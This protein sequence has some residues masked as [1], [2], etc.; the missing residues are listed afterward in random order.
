MDYDKDKRPEKDV[1][2]TK[3]K[4]LAGTEAKLE[5]LT[6]ENIQ[7]FIASLLIKLANFDKNDYKNV[8]EAEAQQE[9]YL[10]KWE[11]LLNDAYRE[12]KPKI[13]AAL[14]EGL[15]AMPEE[16]RGKLIDAFVRVQYQ[17]VKDKDKLFSESREFKVAVREKDAEKLKNLIIG[18]FSQ[19]TSADLA[20]KQ[21]IAAWLERGKNKF[22]TKLAKDAEMDTKD[23]V[24]VVDSAFA[25]VLK[26][27]ETT[28]FAPD[29]KRKEPLV[30]STLLNLIDRNVLQLSGE[31]KKT[32]GGFIHIETKE[33]DVF[34]TGLFDDSLHL[35]ECM[36]TGVCTWNDRPRQV[37][38]GPHFAVIA[39]KDKQGRVYAS[40][41]VQLVKTPIDGYG[42]AAS[43][44]GYYILSLTGINMHHGKIPLD[45]EKAFLSIV[46][47]AHRL[48]KAAGITA[49]IPTDKI[50]NSQ[51]D[52]GHARIARLATKGYL[53]RR[54]LTKTVV[55]S[56]SP[57]YTY[58][59]VYAINLPESTF[60]LKEASIQNVL[61]Y[62]GNGKVKAEP[63]Q[64][65]KSEHAVTI[66]NFIEFNSKGNIAVKEAEA[67]ALR[68]GEVMKGFPAGIL[69][70][71]KLTAPFNGE[72]VRIEVDLSLSESKILKNAQ[73]VKLAIGRD[74]LYSEGKIETLTLSEHLSE[75]AAA[76]LLGDY[77]QLKTASRTNENAFLKLAL[78]KALINRSNYL[79]M[80][81]KVINR[82]T[83]FL[84]NY[85]EEKTLDQKRELV[86]KYRVNLDGYTKS[87]KG[88]FQWN[89]FLNV[90]DD[91]D[92]M[93]LAINY[94]HI[95]L[96]NSSIGDGEIAKIIASIKDVNVADKVSIA[97]VRNLLKEFMFG[98]K[99]KLRIGDQVKEKSVFGNFH[100]PRIAGMREVL[101]KTQAQNEFYKT[102]RELLAIMLP[103]PK[104]KLDAEISRLVD[105]NLFSSPKREEAIKNE[106]EEMII[107]FLGGNSLRPLKE[108]LSAQRG[109][110]TIPYASF[111]NR[112]LNT[113][114]D[115]DSY[116]FLRY[117]LDTDGINYS[118]L[119]GNTD[120]PAQGKDWL[121]DLF[122][123]SPKEKGPGD[124][125][126]LSINADVGGINL[127]PANLAIDEE[128]S[129]LNLN[130]SPADLEILQNSNFNGF[131]PVI[132]Q[133]VPITNLPLILGVQQKKAEPFKV[134]SASP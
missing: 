47:T 72:R 63:L 42:G 90:M 74:I 91:A 99:V 118:L 67:L 30:L 75:L 107:R 28:Q 15:A 130:I 119:E 103:F 115:A 36:A 25:L 12:H 86:A 100:D 49:V 102:M 127:N 134:S 54:D 46:E 35:M 50:I 45:P 101:L 93:F 21:V 24:P 48:A 81:Y 3:L 41:Q 39:L 68:I 121:Q 34:Y 128:G 106:L 77:E 17:S 122:I 38:D 76:V 110:K 26:Y 43:P 98:G 33:K 108:H 116:E 4:G 23:V 6:A 92:P 111:L 10:A 32:L 7:T 96:S 80:Y 69:E 78:I 131:T 113:G 97:G 65:K 19:V 18:W 85:W 82:F 117:A 61:S 51:T 83:W 132:I 52:R 133:I 5:N 114:D 95:L 60:S 55:L 2:L 84:Q 29:A 44:K 73:E 94:L 120:T 1:F 11:L 58:D 104:D 53:T 20:D 124:K 62:G 64:D 66:E 89:A 14:K 59:Q 8:P 40:S 87:V 112:D 31:V 88:V 22:V 105:K 37:R 16:A 109:F 57:S 125:A 71:V 70:D 129:D 9:G 79:P 123:M 126:M 56:K 13:E 27:L